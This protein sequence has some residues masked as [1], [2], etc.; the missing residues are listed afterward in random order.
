MK[1]TPSHT[2]TFATLSLCFSVWV[3]MILLAFSSVSCMKSR[4]LESKPSSPPLCRLGWGDVNGRCVAMGL[5]PLNLHFKFGPGLRELDSTDHKSQGVA[6]T[7]TSS[8]LTM[9]CKILF[10]LL[11]TQA[12]SFSPFLVPHTKVRSIP[13]CDLF[14]TFCLIPRFF[15]FKI[16]FDSD[17]FAAAPFYLRNIY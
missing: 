4:R 8:E 14:E 6:T 10:A 11:L 15:N 3:F 7:T 16:S 5:S 17:F 9:I 2:H 13:M 12:V 1:T